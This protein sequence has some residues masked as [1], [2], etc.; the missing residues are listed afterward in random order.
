[1]TDA[2]GNECLSGAAGD[3]GALAVL[4]AG[5][6]K[7]GSACVA[8]SGG[9]DSSL[10]LAAAT[11]ALGR[12]NVVAFTAVSPTYL[13]EELDVAR[14]V[15]GDLGITHVVSETHEFDDGSFTSN[16]RDRCYWCKR[17]LVAEMSRV[18]G[19]AGCA[20][21]LDG[22]NLDDLGDHR[23]GM[24][25][26]GEAGV[27]H[28]LLD[29]GIGKEQVRR[30]ARRLG[31]ST[32][33]AP[34]QACLASRIPYGR[35][36]TEEKLAVVAAAEAALRAL[37]FRECRVRHH[38]AIAR[39]EVGARRSGAR[40]GR[41]PGA[42]RTPAQGPRVHLRDPRP[43]RLPLREHERGAGARDE[44]GA[45]AGR[46][47]APARVLDEMPQRRAAVGRVTTVFGKFLRALGR[48][49]RTAV[50]EIGE[51]VRA[52]QDATPRPRAKLE[53]VTSYAGLHA[54]WLHR[55][56]HKLSDLGVPVVP[57]WVSQFNR[58]VTGIESTPALNIGE[59]LFIDHGAGVVIGETAEIGDN[60]TMYQGVTSVAPARSPASVIPTV[61]DN[62]VFGAGARCWER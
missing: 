34:Q 13:P 1:M 14:R 55:L 58:F 28:P 49:A 10:V 56:A 39:V 33:D 61:G 11:Q 27:L 54:L 19:E 48:D 30:L 15:A 16:P 41:R 57:R 20:A 45:G 38:D 17:E 46:G 6:A 50:D 32:W 12:P 26:A 40:G 29:A 43:R 25:A 18:A 9:V 53:I 2:A 22:A 36:I 3:D 59:G 7:L 60:V 44:R 62:V 42:D 51:D 21:L 47:R 52:V 31:L 4:E 24:R 23:P 35:P 8:F 37:G 5:L